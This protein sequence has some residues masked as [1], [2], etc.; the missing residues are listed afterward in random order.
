MRNAGIAV[1]VGSVTVG[2]ALLL[3]WLV[4]FVTGFTAGGL[5]HLLLVFAILIIPAGVVAGVALLFV[6]NARARKPSS[7]GR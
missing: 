5:I 2:V 6:A 4:G 1:L 7:G 3:V